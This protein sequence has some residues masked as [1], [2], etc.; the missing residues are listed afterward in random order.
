MAT[1]RSVL[2]ARRM[3]CAALGGALAVLLLTALQTTLAR[4]AVDAS[5]WY[6]DGAGSDTHDCQSPATACATV[7]AAVSKAGPGDVIHIA[8]GVYDANLDLQEITLSGAGMDA[9]ILDG[10]Q[11]ARVITATLAVTLTDLTVRNGRTTGSN[12]G[13]GIFNFGEMLLQRVRVV[14]NTAAGSG[15][16]V[17]NGNRL[18]LQ[19][20]EILSN[21]ADELGGGVYNFSH[22]SF[23]RYLTV[24][25]STVAGNQAVA[26]GGVY[27]NGAAHIADATFRENHA[28][29]QGGGGL[30]TSTGPVTVMRSTFHG[31]RADSYYGGGILNNSSVIT[32]TNVTI[33]DNEAQ[34]GGALANLFTDATT[35]LESSTVAYNRS[36][37]SGLVVYG[38]IAAN[39]GATTIHNSIIAHNEGRNCLTGGTWTSAGYNLSSD[40]RCQLTAAGDLQSTDPLLAPLGDYSGNT[41]THALLPDSA[42]LD[43]G[44]PADCPTTDQRGVA[45][46]VDGDNDG[47]AVC[48][49]GAFE[50]RSSLSV[51]DVSVDEGDSG[52]VSAV[53]TVTLT[54]TSTQT[55]SVAYATADG[56]ATAGSDYTAVSGTLVFNPGVAVQ[57]IAV[58]ILGD[59]AEEPD[60][61]FVVRL[62]APQNGDLLDGEATGTILDDDGLSSLT[63]QDVSV[64][65][66]NTGSVN[67]DFVVS[68]SP[69]SPHSVSVDYA[70]VDGTATAGSDY[71]ATSGT[72]VFA[73]GETEK[74]ISVSIL[75]DVV[76]EADESFSLILSNPTDSILVDGQ[77]DGVIQDDD[78]AQVR[79]GGSVQVVEGNGGN[80]QAVLTVTLTT[81]TAF[82][83]T[84][85]YVTQSA[86]CGPTFATPDEDYLAAT[87]T[88]T[89]TPGQVQQQ[90]SV[91]ILGDLIHEEDET[92]SVNLRNPDPIAV[93]TSTAF[94]TILNDDAFRIYLPLV[95]R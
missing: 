85:D 69:A 52:A 32:L 25:Q 75:G 81:P 41:W 44:D 62:S 54:P 5:E 38:G 48:D 86:C 84:V 16:G 71:L 18:E 58:P 56:T 76:D 91:A 51:A 37:G 20:S 82:P 87:G 21:T 6:V 4:A 33:S 77:A 79:M 64:E 67:A 90:I 24:T 30:A 65:E 1:R 29:S 89:F 95:T 63:V 70:T 8:A 23:T 60:E 19:E 43:N 46:P 42:A 11:R 74:T 94:V 45:R 31:N 2:L 50:L 15:G 66:G 40:Q 59:T 35:L 9:T 17:Y 93:G 68:L 27:N 10:G 34:T 57:T 22:P 3:A 72:L 88:L 7:A 92:F 49:K 80:T 61:T 78:T 36:S 47:T 39:T 13:G 26:G 53:F 12:H 83:V 73:A 55:V 14:D 28:T